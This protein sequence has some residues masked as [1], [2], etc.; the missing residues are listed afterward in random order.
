MQSF[1]VLAARFDQDPDAVLSDHLVQRYIMWLKQL[2]TKERTS[3]LKQIA[4]ALR[5]PESSLVTDGDQRATGTIR[6][7]SG[8]TVSLP[9]A[10]VR[11][12]EALTSE[13]HLWLVPLLRASEELQRDRTDEAIRL[14]RSTLAIVPD[15]PVALN[16]LAYVLYQHNQPSDSKPSPTTSDRLSEAL[17]LATRAVA[18]DSNNPAYRQTRAVIAVD[19]LDWTTAVEDLRFCLD[20]NYRFSETLPLLKR[21]EAQK[22]KLESR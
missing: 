14:L 20:A 6:L 2:D 17:D 12:H 13:D 1:F 9:L 3:Q 16:N 11:F 15:H 22:Q 7:S 5:F 10:V 19:L 4:L 8:D 21:A 18:A